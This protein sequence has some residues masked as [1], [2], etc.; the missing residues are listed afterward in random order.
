MPFDFDTAKIPFHDVKVGAGGFPGCPVDQ[1]KV[2]DVISEA[3][4]FAISQRPKIPAVVAKPADAVQTKKVDLTKEDLGQILNRSD[5]QSGTVF[6]ASGSGLRT[7]SPV[8]ISGRSVRVIFHQADGPPL[9]LQP[10]IP[11]QKAKPDFVGLFNIEN[12]S[13][14]LQSGILEAAQSLKGAAPPWLINAKNASV[15]IRGCQLNGPLLQ[16]L[17]QHQGLI[18]WTTT[19]TTPPT[20]GTELPFLSIND[21]LLLSTGVGIRAECSQG[22]V[23]L[24]NSIVAVRGSGIT[25]VPV[26]T[27]NKYLANVDLQH[28]TFSATKAAI[29]IE[30]AGGTEE[31]PSPMRLYIDYCAVV[32]PLA[33]K[34]DEARDAAVAECVGPVREQKQIEWWGTSNG[35]GKE[36]RVWLRQ[37]TSEP[38]ASLAG[39][40]VAWGE[41]HVVRMLT[42]T[43]GV[44]LNLALPTK[45]LSLKAISF[46][47]DPK[48]AG[49]TW[50]DGGGPVGADIR[51]IDDAMAAT[52][53]AAETKSGSTNAAPKNQA[54]KKPGD[55]GF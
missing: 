8:K 46:A 14:D 38:I 4:L 28:V 22:N 44:H 7:M 12:G 45:W 55:V 27:N 13:L 32:P 18:Q 39:W 50:A 23:F 26:R 35:I 53:A 11:D 17:E 20:P 43:K 5:W 10:K 47:L 33:F 15:I 40:N 37:S 9:K 25:I 19:A 52:K 51:G 41:A 54:P 1:L 29:R 3:R 16:D 48:S 42:E 30:A 21:S 31:F 49:A 36:V 6:E 2:P 24:R 34:A